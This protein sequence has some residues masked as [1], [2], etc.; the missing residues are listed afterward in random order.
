MND[1]KNCAKGARG[2]ELLVQ[3]GEKSE[4]A[5]FQYVPYVL[6]NGEE[7]KGEVEDF[8][9]DVCSAFNSPPKPCARDI[10]V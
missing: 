7:W 5:N 6:I 2:Q 10:F 9:N 8:M 1:V 4:R 3:Y